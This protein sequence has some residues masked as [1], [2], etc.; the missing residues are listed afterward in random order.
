MLTFF[1]D[2]DA[3]IASGDRPT[4]LPERDLLEAY[5]L[6]FV[7]KPAF[8]ESL[9]ILRE[10]AALPVEAQLRV[11]GDGRQDGQDVVVVVTARDQEALDALAIGTSAA[12]DVERAEFPGNPP[13]MAQQPYALLDSAGVVVRIQNSALSGLKLAIQGTR[14]A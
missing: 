5:L 9:A 7:K 11:N 4:R 10:E 1:F 6:E 12:L 2:G 3:L 8:M 14:I 13:F